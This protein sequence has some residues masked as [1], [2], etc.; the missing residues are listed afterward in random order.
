MEPSS[1]VPVSEP[2][3][4]MTEFRKYWL[5]WAW[6]QARD[7]LSK[8]RLVGNDQGEVKMDLSSLRELMT[9]H[10]RGRVTISAQMISVPCEKTLRVRPSL[11]RRPRGESI[12][13]GPPR[14]GGTPPPPGPG[15]V[16]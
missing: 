13:A 4:T 7:Q 10:T 11:P 15:P 2:A 5:M 3:T 12:L 1:M 16:P 6:S 8:C 14:C 9:A